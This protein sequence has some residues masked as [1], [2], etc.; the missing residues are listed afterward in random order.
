[1]IKEFA[2][3]KVNLFLDVIKK[4][5]D[6]YHNIGTLFC[7]LGLGEWLYAEEIESG[8]V[9]EGGEDVVSSQEDNLVYKAVVALK[10]Y[11]GC[12][13][14]IKLRLEK[15]LPAGAGLGGGSADAAAAL[16][17]AN[18]LWNL[19]LTYDELEKIGSSLGAD[20][21]FLVRGGARFAE[22]I[23]DVQSNVDSGVLDNIESW[24]VLI[25][26]PN[27][28]VSTADAYSQ[29]NPQGDVLWNGFKKQL[30]SSM[31]LGDWKKFGINK[32]EATVFPQYSEIESLKSNMLDRGAGWALM[33]GSGA[34]VFGV[35]ESEEKADDFFKTERKK[36]RFAK[37][38]FFSTKSL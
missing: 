33:S 13:K 19:N 11:S 2:R 17:I 32:F 7:T 15:E 21:P 4:R 9:L 24:T 31:E 14:G 20:I 25:M 18:R 27:C 10:K 12:D 38:T 29:M 6:G 26:T 36:C 34:S 28:F 5:E 22:G 35:F 23:G 1:M 16:R 37:K 3:A 30:Q 8:V